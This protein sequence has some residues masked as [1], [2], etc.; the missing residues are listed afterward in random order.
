MRCCIVVFMGNSLSD[1]EDPFIPFHGAKSERIE[2]DTHGSLVR[3][4]VTRVRSEST[5]NE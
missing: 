5:F 1:P 2:C 3:D 4:L